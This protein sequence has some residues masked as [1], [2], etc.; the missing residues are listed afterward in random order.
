MPANFPNTD[1][2]NPAPIVTV[3][4]TA[5]HPI[6]LKTKPPLAL[7]TLFNQSTNGTT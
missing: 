7:F 4:K 6:N 5:P 2:N 1:I 3:L